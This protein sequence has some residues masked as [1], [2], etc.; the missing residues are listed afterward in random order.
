MQSIIKYT[1]SI[2]ILSLMAFSLQAQRSWDEIEYPELNSFDKPDV[3]EFTL[4]NGIRFYLVEDDELPL[5]NL[6]MIVRTGGF[7]VPD[8][9]AGLNSITGTVMRS[10]GTGS[11]GGDELNELLED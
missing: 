9:K 6:S 5:I 10:G 2:V 8:D 3:E 4:D 1:L 7:L 11:M